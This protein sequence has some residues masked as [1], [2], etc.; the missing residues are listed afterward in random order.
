MVRSDRRFPSRA[1]LFLCAIVPFISLCSVQTEAVIRPSEQAHHVTVLQPSEG[2]RIKLSPCR[3]VEGE[4]KGKRG[5][6]LFSHSLHRAHY[7]RCQHW[8]T[9][10]HTLSHSHT[11]CCFH[12]FRAHGT[13]LHSSSR[14]LSNL[15]PSLHPENVMFYVMTT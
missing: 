7:S 13:D 4:V 12:Y 10:A 1:L 2:N 5:S 15:K 14:N 8:E 6:R 9:H 11:Q 3:S